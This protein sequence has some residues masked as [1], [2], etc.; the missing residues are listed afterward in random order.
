MERVLFCPGNR[1]IAY[2]WSA[3]RFGGA[4]N[5]AADNDGYRDFETYL[6]QSGF[7]PVHIIVDLIEE[8]FHS[9]TVPH[10]WG[11]DRAAVLDRAV[12]KFFR[13]S[14]LRSLQV[15]NRQKN[16]RRDLEVLISGLGN[17]TILRRWI[18][19]LE[20]TRVPVK[21]IYSLPLLGQSLLTSLKVRTRQVLLVSQQSSMTLRQSFYDKGFLK[22]S[23]LALHRMSHDIS[24]NDIKIIQTDINDTLQF[25]RSQRL[26]AR[27]EPLEVC[28]VVRDELYES[29]DL[30]LQGDKPV[31]Y[32]VLRQRDV[33]TQVGISGGLPTHFS[34][35]LFAHALL[36]KVTIANHYAPRKLTRFYRYHLARKLLLAA[37]GV[38]LVV[39]A[40]FTASR[41]YE[42][43]LLHRYALE[44]RVN[45]PAYGL[46]DSQQFTRV[47]SY[48]HAPGALA[49]AVETVAL[50]ELY[51]RPTP[52]RLLTN[53]ARVLSRNDNIKIT[54][55]NWLIHAQSDV[56]IGG[57][58]AQPRSAHDS[59]LDSA[60]IGYEIVGIEGEVVA[61]ADNYRNAIEL[62]DLFV[63][64]IVKTRQYSYVKVETTPFN[65]GSKTGLAGDSGTSANEILASRS[66]FELRLT[67]NKLEN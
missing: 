11:R 25:L 6:Q 26:L 59:E 65:I 30:G 37:A 1:M 35:G 41:Y 8:E 51:S 49:S 66:T 40:A 33:A 5:F 64:D 17:A 10:V 9:H 15:Q 57:D 42:V 44:A 48:K 56:K 62:F 14:E 53:L 58:T 18:D 61:Y 13:T 54:R 45:N 29:L 20:R 24:I 31:T 2:D 46:E 55:V 67:L 4:K 21:G 3:G 19:I 28:V 50:L 16:G 52:L 47:E 23:R 32:S 39:A 43:Q 34:D 63:E 60:G 38:V 22:L 27:D 36:D 7:R 12:K